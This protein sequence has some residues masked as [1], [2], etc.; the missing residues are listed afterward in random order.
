MDT[1]DGDDFIIG[2]WDG[3]LWG[4]DEE[5]LIGFYYGQEHPDY[6]RGFR[7]G[8]FEMMAEGGER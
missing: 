3:Y 7:E 4:P 8:Y 5:P 6:V 1:S 2:W